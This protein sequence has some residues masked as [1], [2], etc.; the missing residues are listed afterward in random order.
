[1]N[2][3]ID[4]WFS[5]PV[6]E[7]RRDTATVASTLAEYTLQNARAEAVSITAAP[8]TE[9]AF[10]TGNF[11]SL[12][13]VFRRREAPLQGGFAIALLDRELEASYQVPT[14]WPELSKKLRIQEGAL[15]LPT[16]MEIDG[17]Q[18]LIGWQ[19]VGKRGLVLVGMPMPRNF[20]HAI[21]QLEDSH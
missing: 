20:T 4:K 3:S 19:E 9:K 11:T 17:Q 18:Y 10:Q 7:V 14:T 2:R 15:S 21:Q 16:A 6:E 13:G 12:L 1:M 8:D 5:T